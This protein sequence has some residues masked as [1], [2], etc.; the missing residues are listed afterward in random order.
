[1]TTTVTGQVICAV[2]RVGVWMLTIGETAIQKETKAKM[3][4]LR[5][6]QTR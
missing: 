4:V 6:N 1:M 3:N 5:L 2:S